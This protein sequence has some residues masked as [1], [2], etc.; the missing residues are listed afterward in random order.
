MRPEPINRGSGITDI[1]NAF[2]KEAHV[3]ALNTSDGRSTVA[4]AMIN[5]KLSNKKRA[6]WT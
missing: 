1:Q 4:N 6:I 5:N 3:I 2:E